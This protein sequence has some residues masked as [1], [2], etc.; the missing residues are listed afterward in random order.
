MGGDVGTI[1]EHMIGKC[2]GNIFF[3]IKKKKVYVP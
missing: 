1:S 2:M 3:S